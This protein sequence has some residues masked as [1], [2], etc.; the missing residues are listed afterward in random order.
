VGYLKI[1]APLFA[2]AT[3]TCAPNP[4]ACTANRECP[5]DEQCTAGYCTAAAPGPAD[6]PTDIAEALP[7]Q[8]TTD[9]DQQATLALSAR[10]GSDAPLDFVL[11]SSSE[12]ALGRAAVSGDVLTFTPAPEA[13]GEIALAVAP[14]QGGVEGRPASIAVVVR[15]VDDGPRIYVSTE[16]RTARD[17][18]LD[19]QFNAIDVERYGMV[20][21][22]VSAFTDAT[23]AMIAACDDAGAFTFTPDAGFAGTSRGALIATDGTGGTT[24]LALEIVVE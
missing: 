5:S 11:L 16:L 6:D 4:D 10:G 1:T 7:D 24:T 20:T 19:V 2:L 17:T 15:A 21:F 14:R 23:A 22:A 18:P 3:S 9:E 12:S 13:S 8:L